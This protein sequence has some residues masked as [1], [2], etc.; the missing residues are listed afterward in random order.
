M[1]EKVFRTVIADD[2]PELRRL[3][4]RVVERSGRFEVVGEASN[5]LEAIVVTE[6][7]RPDLLL[8]DVSMPVCDGL[9]ALPQIRAQAPDTVIAM[10]SGFDVGRLGRSALDLGASAYLEKGMRPNE[11]IHVLLDL[12]ERQDEADD[13]EDR[14]PGS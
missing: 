4:R 8:L 7:L 2:L 13:P 10:V 5:G 1:T 14:S 11:M 3:L 12:L 9:E 6:Q